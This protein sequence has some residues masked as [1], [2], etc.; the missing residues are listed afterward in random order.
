MKVDFAQML[1]RSCL[2]VN[3]EAGTTMICM[4]RVQFIP[5]SC[6]QKT[7][8]RFIRLLLVFCCVANHLSC[9]VGEQ[10]GSWGLGRQVFY[11]AGGCLKCHFLEPHSE[12]E[13]K[14]DLSDLVEA[15]PLQIGRT[16]VSVHDSKQARLA[17]RSWTALTVSQRTDLLTYLTT[18]APQMP[19]DSP[20]QAPALRTAAEVQAA[21]AGAPVQPDVYRKMKIV[22]VAGPK[23]HGPGEHDYPA[24]QQQWLELLSAAKNVD[25]D[26]AWEFPSDS[27]LADTDV[28]LFFQKGSFPKPR[29]EKLDKFLKEGGGAVYLHWAVNGSDQ[30]KAFSERIGMAS[31]GGKIKF[32]HGPLT[33]D[34][35]N[36]NHPIVRNMIRLQLYDESYWKLT[37]NSD[38]IL[39]LATS[40]ED[41]TPTP[42]MW[43]K[44]HAP[45]RVFVS[46]PGHYSWTFDDPLFRIVI[47]R[48]IAWTAKEPVDRFNELVTPGSRMKQ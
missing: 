18:A 20:L 28:L 5:N 8:P 9:A 30:V 34:I 15:D 3:R 4:P 10:K 29:P 7:V 23:D 22:L 37:G 40:I 19:L 35:H 14:S 2:G 17:N 47:L 32:R 48:A 42:Q 13:S 24:W 25:V 45:G 46:I 27:Q 11:G 44:D 33:L 36:T 43:V 12:G 26:I 21:L 1:S 6:W 31:W 16:M 39:L 38:D 41:G